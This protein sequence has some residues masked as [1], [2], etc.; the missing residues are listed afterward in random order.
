MSRTPQEW[1]GKT[2]DTPIPARVKLRVFERFKGICQETGQKIRAGDEWDC[3]H[4]IALINGGQNRESNL[5]P[6][7]RS[8]HRAKT[9]RDLAQKKKDQRVR[10]KH[11]GLHKSRNPLPGGRGDNRKRKVSGE[12]VLRSEDE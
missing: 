12:I 9:R 5:R 8:A 7:L 4:K 6:V 10:K 3:D 2:D 11:L 1:I